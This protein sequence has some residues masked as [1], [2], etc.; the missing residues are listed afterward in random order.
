MVNEFMLASGSGD[1]SVQFVEFLDNGGTEE[2]FP[3][4][5]APF[6]LVI[7]DG[8]GN[9]LGEQTLSAN[10]LRAA[11]AADR[12]YLVSTPAADSAFGVTGDEKLT[13]ALPAGSGQ[14]CYVANQNPSAYSCM[15]Y[16]TITKPIQTSSMG[17]GSVHGPVPPNG[18]SDQRQPDGSVIAAAPTPKAKKRH[19]RGRRLRRALGFGNEGRPGA[20]RLELPFG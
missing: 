10:G 2:S 17:T 20:C 16:G 14:V 3:P 6:K 12:E 15:T 18:Q 13:V 9:E 5:F 11:A 19:F 1:G 7:Y 4:V 8:A